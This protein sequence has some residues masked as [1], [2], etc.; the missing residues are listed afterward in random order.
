MSRGERRKPGTDR[1]SLRQVV[2][3]FD[4]QLRKANLI[5][6]M[7]S[8][9]EG[10]G[11]EAR[12]PARML[13]LL[14]GCNMMCTKMVAV[15]V[16]RSGQILMLRGDTIRRIPQPCYSMFFLLIRGKMEFISKAKFQNLSTRLPSFCTNIV[17]D[18]VTIS[19]MITISK[20][21]G[22]RIFPPLYSNYRIK[23]IH[24]K[25]ANRCQDFHKQ[26]NKLPV[27]DLKSMQIQLN[28]MYAL[29]IYTHV[30]IHMSMILA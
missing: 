23:I 13:L 21:R 24:H 18:H 22:T 5:Y 3:G 8:G 27:Y 4:L 2:T 30:D 1:E 6:C 16:E 25:K 28:F 9:L 20:L 19:N 12:K 7:E 15:E 26:R 11:V 17:S 14:S 29:Y 10:A